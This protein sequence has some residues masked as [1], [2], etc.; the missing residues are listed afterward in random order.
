MGLFQAKEL[1]DYEKSQS[2]SHVSFNP[3]EMLDGTLLYD[4]FANITSPK[5][6]ENHNNV[7]FLASVNSDK[8]NIGRLKI[9]L[10][11][12]VANL[13]KKEINE[14]NEFLNQ[15]QSYLPQELKYTATSVKQ[16]NNACARLNLS[17]QAVIEDAIRRFTLDKKQSI[18]IPSNFGFDETGQLTINENIIVGDDTTIA[19]L[20]QKPNGEKVFRNII[21]LQL[22]AFYNNVITNIKSDLLRLNEILPSDCPK[23]T[24]NQA[25]YL[26]FNLWCEQTGQK[27]VDV[28]N[29]YV[30]KYNY[31]HPNDIITLTD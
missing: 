14:V 2:K 30:A 23:L 18:E 19:E 20:I 28:I 13:F 9:N 29:K 4:Y 7:F 22:G 16:F 24:Y 12:K 17:A 26:A 25:S 27:P 31:E 3:T 21:R 11:Y 6:T 1:K 5:G 15:I 8:S 10:N